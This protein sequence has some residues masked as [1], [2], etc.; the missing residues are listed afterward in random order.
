MEIGIAIDLKSGSR[1]GECQFCGTVSKRPV[2]LLSMSTMT[3]TLLEQGTKLASLERSSAEKE[4]D[5]DLELVI[6]WQAGDLDAFAALVRRHE[7][8]VFRLLLRMLG[9]RDEAEDLSQE[10]FLNL[11]RHGKRFRRESKFSTFVYRVAVNVALNRR[12]SLGRKRARMKA[13]AV[14]QTTGD[15]L[16]TSPIGPEAST[17]SHEL[18]N[19]VQ[20]AISQLSPG[21]RAPLILYDIEGQPYSEIA[22]VLGVAEGTVKSRIH[23]ARNA[24]RT[25]LGDL[26]KELPSINEI[27]C[28]EPE[29]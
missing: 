24:L 20:L 25:I 16:P 14:S 22:S 6:S 19:E 4:A 11:H 9:D 15:N 7:R 2:S 23:R 21:L 1:Q 10:T 17:L 13:L 5:P 8:R 12:R 26:V 3:Q 27:S 29:K 28:E 18:Q